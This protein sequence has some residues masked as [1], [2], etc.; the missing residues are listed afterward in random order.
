MQSP[1]IA[2]P[3]VRDTTFQNLMAQVS[4]LERFFTDLRSR[5]PRSSKD[6]LE[7]HSGLHG[8]NI[9]P[10]GQQAYLRSEETED[11]AQVRIAKS[12]CLGMAYGL[13]E[14]AIKAL[15][16]PNTKPVLYKETYSGEVE[17][18]FGKICAWNN[19]SMVEK[20][21]WPDHWL[22]FDRLRIVRNRLMHDGGIMPPEGARNKQQID[23][24][25]SI[26]KR[27]QDGKHGLH[28]KPLREHSMYQVLVIDDI[29]FTRTLA[30]FQKFATKVSNGILRI[31]PDYD[32]YKDPF[33][34]H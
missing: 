34:G 14:E 21:K 20:E 12:I 27:Q 16:P 31:T 29:E 23:F 30:W 2:D 6:I 9:S 7:K 33:D 26:Q 19:A 5:H 3:H 25:E 32:G 11:R 10:Q 24:F 4:R 17:K 1:D 22:E 28:F 13:T 15:L 18:L 8:D